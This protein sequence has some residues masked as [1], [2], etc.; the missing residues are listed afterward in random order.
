MENVFEEAV[1]D[2]ND[3]AVD[4]S[5]TLG[6]EYDLDLTPEED[7]TPAEVDSDEGEDGGEAFE[8]YADNPTNQAFAQM[9]TQNKQ[10][11]EKFN[12]LDA[13][14]KAAGLNGV[15]D[16][17]AKSK[18]AQIKQEAKE[19]GIPEA[20]ARELAEMREFREEIKQ[21]DIQQ[22][23][24]ARESRLVSNLQDFI[25][26]NNLSEGSVRKMSDDLMRDGLTNDF[27]MDLPKAALNRIL[28]AYAGTSEQKL[29]E[30]KDAIKTELPLDQTSKVSNE[31]INKEIDE[32]ARMFA[33]K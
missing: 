3:A 4:E 2:N 30:K 18:E 20:V 9:R 11:A 6:S 32:L 22:E 13:I 10:Y 26:K 31:T 23:Y 14:A 21:R 27:L 1:A 7:E 15:D 28:S 33:G 17:I 5:S 19:Q 24:Q 25:G 16:L 8:N 12:E 29:L